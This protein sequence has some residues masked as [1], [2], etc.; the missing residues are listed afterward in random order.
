MICDPCDLVPSS[1]VSSLLLPELLRVPG[2]HARPEPVH[3]LQQ[4]A[5][6]PVHRRAPAPPSRLHVAVRRRARATPEGLQLPPCGR[7][8]QDICG[9]PACRSHLKSLVLDSFVSPPAL[10]LLVSLVSG[11]SKTMNN[12]WRWRRLI[13]VPG[14][15]CALLHLSLTRGPDSAQ[16]V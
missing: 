12:T 1:S 4:V 7:T 15:P 16:L 11:G 3:S 6:L 10:C 9:R 13:R 14:G 5:V 2:A 8:R